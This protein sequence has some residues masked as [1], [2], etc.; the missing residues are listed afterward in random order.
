MDVRI[1]EPKEDGKTKND[2]LSLSPGA[3]TD[4]WSG[5]KSAD[6]RRWDVIKQTIASQLKYELTIA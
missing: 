1:Y 5:A 2:H 6:V 3:Q 4:L